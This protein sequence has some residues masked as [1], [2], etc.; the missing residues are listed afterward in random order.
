MRPG[1]AT[2][3]KNFFYGFD[4]SMLGNREKVKI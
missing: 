2:A 3:N 1:R 4:G